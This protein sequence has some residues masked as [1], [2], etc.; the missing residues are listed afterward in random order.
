MATPPRKVKAAPPPPAGEGWE[1]LR[2]R[3]RSEFQP[4]DER[5]KNAAHER[6]D[7]IAMRRGRIVEENAD[8]EPELVY[9]HNRRATRHNKPPAIHRKRALTRMN[10]EER[11]E[12][13]A[14]HANRNAMWHSDDIVPVSPLGRKP[15]TANT[16]A[17]KRPRHTAPLNQEGGTR[18]KR[19]SSTRRKA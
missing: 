9:T 3:W 5:H 18:R 13:N 14:R 15:T 6:R 19:S 1:G 7:A 16:R 10:N 4:K 12:T 11:N 17:P 2:G 8:A